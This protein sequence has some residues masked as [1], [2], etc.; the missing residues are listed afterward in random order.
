MAD[1]YGKL[2]GICLITPCFKPIKNSFRTAP[3]PA[4]CGHAMAI[5]NG[6]GEGAGAAIHDPITRRAMN[7]VAM[8]GEDFCHHGGCLRPKGSATK[9]LVARLVSAKA[10]RDQRIGG[11]G[12]REAFAPCHIQRRVEGQA[13]CGTSSGHGFHPTA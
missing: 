13:P 11:M 4:E 8:R 10:A 7:A 2:P 12:R 3:F 1:A 5:G 9:A 6:A